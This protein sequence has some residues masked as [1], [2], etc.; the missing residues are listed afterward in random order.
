MWAVCIHGGHRLLEKA[1]ASLQ[2]VIFADSTR[3]DV[4]CT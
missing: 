4:H 2:F 3:V 1:E